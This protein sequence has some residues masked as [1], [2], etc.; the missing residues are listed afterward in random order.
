MQRLHK[1]LIKFFPH[2]KPLAEKQDLKTQK[3]FFNH[4]FSFDT[5]G[6]ISCPS[7]GNSCI[8]VIVEAFTDY[9]ALNHVPYCFEFYA[10][11]TLY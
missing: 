4:K 9:V 5:K 3:R 6:P 2:Q 11:T 8:M 1:M 7:E 10:Y